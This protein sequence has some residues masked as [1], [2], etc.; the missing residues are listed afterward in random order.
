MR[1]FAVQV[2]T[3]KEDSYI[4]RLERSLAFRS[5]RQ[6]FVFPKRRLPIRK[7]G[8]VTEEL[9]SVFSGYIF[10]TVDSIDAELFNIM[11]STKDFLR[12]L[13][14]NSEITALEGRDLTILEH[15]IRMGSI[16][17]ISTV[18]FDKNDRI[19]IKS[20]PMKGLEG[21]IVAVNKRKRRAKIS[22]DFAN[23]NFLIDFAFDIL[24]EAVNG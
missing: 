14:N 1:F 6:Q 18:T 3:L 7:G 15:F 20:G 23:E 4:S 21:S 16:A 17:E 2:R 11:R 12:F 8:K 5:E 13:K 24:E 9:Q 10:V 19:A 22:L